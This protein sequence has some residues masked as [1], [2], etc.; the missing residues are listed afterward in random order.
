MQESRPNTA[1][2]CPYPRSFGT[3]KGRNLDR[4]DDIIADEMLL[5]EDAPQ[6]LGLAET[7]TP[8]WL[9]KKLQLAWKLFE[10]VEN[11]VQVADR[12]VQAIFAANTLLVAAISFQSQ[13]LS[14]SLHK[15]SL[16]LAAALVL[17]VRL[18]LLTCI[19]CSSLSAIVALFPRVRGSV[20]SNRNLLFFGDIAALPD[21]HFID[22]FLEMPTGDK[23]RQLL[24]QIHTVSCLVAEKFTWT[25]RAGTALVL[26]LLLWITLQII[27]MVPG[28]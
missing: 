27:Q 10:S 18:L 1:N 17:V 21:A 11:Q 3:K 16:G 19:G 26:S 8:E 22:G 15:G 4:A 12:K 9:E 24:R 14:T 25:R 28:L 13:G 2:K 23:V 5:V 7:Q 20:S 6:D